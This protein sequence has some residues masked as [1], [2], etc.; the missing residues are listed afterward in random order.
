LT[1]LAFLLRRARSVSRSK[2]LRE[3][4]PGRGKSTGAADENATGSAN[5]WSKTDS[6]RADRLASRPVHLRM[7][8]FDRG[9][10][11][12]LWAIGLGLYIL[13][14]ALGIGIDAAIAF[15]VAGLAAAVIYFF[16]RIYGEEP[17][18]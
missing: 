10:T 17:L 7:P 5:F 13:L 15:I 12:G 4:V 2:S 14:F 9:L 6:L 3:T 16:I 1:A 18:R 11:S 8:S